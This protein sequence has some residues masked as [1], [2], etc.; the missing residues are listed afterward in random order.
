MDI[1]NWF[2][3]YLKFPLELVLA[4][5]MFTYWIP[6]R[7]KWLMRLIFFLVIL[8]ISSFLLTQAFSDPME[9]AVY[10]F[11][12]LISVLG[13]FAVFRYS[14][15]DALYRG[16]A[17]Y[18]TQHIANSLSSILMYCLIPSLQKG[19]ISA[20]I[21][22]LTYLLSYSAAYALIYL[23]FVRRMHKEGLYNVNNLFFILFL[24][25]MLF[26]VVVLNYCR[27]YFIPWEGNIFTHILFSCYSIIG[28]TF[29][30]FVQAGLHRQSHFTQQ[31]EISEQ[32][33]YNQ[34]KQYQLSQESISTINLK[35]HDLKHQM[36]SL[37]KN[38]SD[39]SARQ[40]LKEIEAA[41]MI[42]DSAIHTDNAVLDVILTEKSLLCE[43][44]QIQLTC[45]IDRSDFPNVSDGDLYSIFGNLLDNAIESVMELPDPSQRV[46]GLN[47]TT[48]GN[49][50]IIHTENYFNHPI[51]MNNG[52]PI[53]TKEDKRFH[54]FGM[55]SLQLLAERYGGTL[56]VKPD[57]NIFN[58]DII[59][60]MSSHL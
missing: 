5:A 11:I 1:E 52:L 16:I 39:P 21:N 43:Q 58:V 20:D 15:M 51:I 28:C 18:A 46:I 17:A 56:S 50:L 8:L 57:G 38:L 9:M 3:C 41:V 7:N 35:C 32:L 25:I 30:L 6:K 22:M 27:V 44:H 47:I 60:P 26:M 2:T 55:R 54:G 29:S 36:A 24:T 40:I 37:R 4:E 53:T 23:F 19:I 31:L 13:I 14:F 33:L 49:L 42:Y 34:Q 10:I 48:S 45:M 12:F 59:I